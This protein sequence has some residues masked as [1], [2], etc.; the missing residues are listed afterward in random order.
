M[1]QYAGLDATNVFM[2]A[3]HRDE[4]KSKDMIGR[5]ASKAAELE[6]QKKG[7]LVQKLFNWGKK[8]EGNG[9]PETEK[10]GDIGFATRGQGP[11]YF[12]PKYEPTEVP[13]GTNT[14][15]LAGAEEYKSIEETPTEEEKPA[16]KA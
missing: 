9:A 13:E 15:R 3:H 14:L 4:P 1:V 11:K 8:G 12:S 16:E 10:Y 7:S 5:L 6:A 2:S